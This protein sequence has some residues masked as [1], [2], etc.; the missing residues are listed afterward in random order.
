MFAQSVQAGARRETEHARVPDEVTRSQVL[1]GGVARGLLDEALDGECARCRQRLA[2][3]DVPERG[4]GTGGGDAERH[5]AAGRGQIDRAAA[6]LPERGRI[7]NQVIG[8]QHEQH[9]VLAVFATG[10]QGCERDRRPRIASLGL[11][12]QRQRV[13]QVRRG[14]VFDHLV[15]VGD[16]GDNGQLDDPVQPDHALGRRLQQRA[17]VGQPDEWFGHRFA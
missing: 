6:R 17:A 5:Q 8:G 7:L 4:I 14:Q 11:E 12:Q 9:A 13:R 1:L 16:I 15:G 10:P 3:F 2:P